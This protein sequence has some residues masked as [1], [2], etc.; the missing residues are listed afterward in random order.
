[1]PR[2][3]RSQA[4]GQC[5]PMPAR[6]RSRSHGPNGR[7]RSSSRARPLPRSACRGRRHRPAPDRRPSA[8]RSGA[9]AGQDHAGALDRVR[10]IV[11]SA[12]ARARA[13][14]SSPQPGLSNSR[15][16]R[17]NIRL[18]PLRRQ[19]GL[20]HD[21][22]G[23]RFGPVQNKRRERRGLPSSPFLDSACSV[24]LGLPLLGAAL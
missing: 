11:S 23:R 1:M 3:G 7:G 16:V 10:T 14:A 24:V 9:R 15:C 6:P 17:A 19:L 13:G 12:I 2:A 4:S 8:R 18:L 5:R 22:F 20:A 21:S